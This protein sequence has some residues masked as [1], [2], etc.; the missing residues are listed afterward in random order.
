MVADTCL[1]V[2]DP[3][4][5]VDT[6]SNEILSIWR[7]GQIIDLSTTAGPAHVLDSPCLFIVHGILRHGRHR[8]I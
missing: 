6:A 3:C 2:E 8:G 4:S 1:S 7:P 5:V